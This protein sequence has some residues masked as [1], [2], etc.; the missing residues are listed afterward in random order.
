MMLI[1]PVSYY[2]NATPRAT[3]TKLN[4]SHR[5]SVSEW[6]RHGYIIIN[7]TEV[8]IYDRAGK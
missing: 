1:S 8:D 7:K 3:T 5:G 2:R 4:R 6:A